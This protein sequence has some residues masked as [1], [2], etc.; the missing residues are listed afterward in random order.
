MSASILNILPK[1]VAARGNPGKDVGR[2]NS[3]KYLSIRGLTVRPKIKS[4]GLQP[5][6]NVIPR[7]ITKAPPL[8]IMVHVKALPA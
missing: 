8:K 6:K 4:E 2:K 3:P 1:Y 5:K 7:S